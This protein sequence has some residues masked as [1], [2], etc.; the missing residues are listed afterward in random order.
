MGFKER[1]KEKR[2]EANLT[3]VEPNICWAA[4]GLM[5]R[6]LMKRAAQKQPEILTN[7]WEK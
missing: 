3:Q 1:L 4:A 6:M 7:S 2:V 5:W